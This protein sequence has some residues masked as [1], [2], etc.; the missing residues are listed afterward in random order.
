M[1][2]AEA[3]DSTLCEIG[4]QIDRV[5]FIDLP[6]E[7]IIGRITDRR[8]DPTT[9]EIY[10]LGYAPPPDEVKARLIQRRDDKPETVA[11]RLQQYHTETAQMIRYYDCRGVVSRIDGAGSPDDVAKRIVAEFQ[12]K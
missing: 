9:G 11:T 8:I 6:D 4:V 3:F 12:I 1:F 5:V 7:E 10:H 2:Q